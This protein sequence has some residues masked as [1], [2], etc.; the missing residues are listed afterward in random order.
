MYTCYCVIPPQLNSI[1][2]RAESSE[3]GQLHLMTKMGKYVGIYRTQKDC[4][5]IGLLVNKCLAST[6]FSHVSGKTAICPINFTSIQHVGD[7]D[8][9]SKR[10]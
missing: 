1:H 9:R 5:G 7:L 8:C 3:Q 2:G 6:L 4:L 10:L